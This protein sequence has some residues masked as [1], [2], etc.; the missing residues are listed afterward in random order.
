MLK[1]LIP[2]V[3]HLTTLKVL[4]IGPSVIPLEILPDR[5]E[6]SDLKQMLQVY[7]SGMFTLGSRR[8]IRGTLPSSLS[9]LTALETLA[10]FMASHYFFT[11]N[12]LSAKKP[13]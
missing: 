13:L 10:L 12:G 2:V 5:Q 3:G 11:G 9:S 8:E 7:L 4:G 1:Q 6:L